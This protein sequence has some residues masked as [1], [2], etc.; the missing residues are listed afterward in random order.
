MRSKL[1]PRHWLRLLGV[2]P[3]ALLLVLVRVRAPPLPA[4]H[5]AVPGM[6]TGIDVSHWQ[7]PSAGPTSRPPA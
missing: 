5:T 3:L 4:C 7:G 2:A 6:L 1:L